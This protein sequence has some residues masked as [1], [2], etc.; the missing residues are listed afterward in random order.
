MKLSLSRALIWIFTSVLVISG[1]CYLGFFAHKW[2]CEKRSY[3]DKYNIVEIMQ[4]T[5]ENN[6][7]SCDYLA[8]LL[9][10]SYDKP[11]NLFHFD[12]VKAQ[13]AL[14]KSPFIKEGKVKKVGPKSIYVDYVLRTPMAILNNWENA[15]IDDEGFIFPINPVFANEGLLQISFS[16]L[17]GL[18]WGDS[19]KTKE[20]FILATKLFELLNTEQFSKVFKLV[21]LDLSRAF[22]KSY[23]K[24]EIVAICEDVILLNGKTFVFP[25]IL[26]LDPQIYEKQL[27]NFLTLLDTMDKDYV[28]QLE[29]NNKTFSTDVVNF[30]PR[31][32]DLRIDKL[33]FIDEN[34]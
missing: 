4:P 16:D 18:T 14:L 28:K 8:Q 22:L 23:G 1:P 15:A 24:R 6:R 3:E 27:F 10:L 2:V 33:A 25:K 11:V 21:K 5:G 31:E 30:A 13:R 12:V 29:K 32:V 17:Q 9:S 34:N 19:V 20:E 7:L 26:R